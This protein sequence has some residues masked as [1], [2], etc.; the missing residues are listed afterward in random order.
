MSLS[1]L[2]REMELEPMH[3]AAE[4]NLLSEQQSLLN[5][6]HLYTRR[7]IQINFFFGCLQGSSG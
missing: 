7:I 3:D 4:I 1:L 5:E 2:I 6:V